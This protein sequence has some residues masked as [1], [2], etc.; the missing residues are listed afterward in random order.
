MSISGVLERAATR[1][2]ARNM[3]L[4][5][6]SVHFTPK[7][8]DSLAH[9]GDEVVLARVNE[10]PI[11]AYSE[12]LA[13]KARVT[14][15]KAVAMMVTS[16][17]VMNCVKHSEA[18]IALRLQVDA[19]ALATGGASLS[20][21]LSVSSFVTTVSPSFSLVVGDETG[22]VSDIATVFVTLC[23]KVLFCGIEEGDLG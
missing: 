12:A 2:P 13:A 7:R 5:A 21:A 1:L 17:A 15:G 6:N 11:Q 22:C 10:L 14:V 9:I 19:T 8:S 16:K 23:P 18:M 4:A 3:E 20:I